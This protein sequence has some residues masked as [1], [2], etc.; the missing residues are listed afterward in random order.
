MGKINTTESY[1]NTTE[2][3]DFVCERSDEKKAGEAVRCVQPG[4]CLQPS[5]PFPVPL[6]S[7]GLSFQPDPVS[8]LAPCGQSESS[9]ISYCRMI[10]V[11]R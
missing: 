6:T 11:F 2:R 4:C 1:S 10:S 8:K 3:Y 9:Q 7:R 5:L